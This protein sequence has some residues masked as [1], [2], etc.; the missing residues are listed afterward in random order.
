MASDRGIAARSILGESWQIVTLPSVAVVRRL[1]LDRVTRFGQ[2]RGMRVAV[3]GH[4]EW[5]EFVRVPRVPAAGEIV[6]TRDAWAEPGGGG[7]VA[8]V[9]LA[10][11]AG[12]CTFFTALA[13]DALRGDPC[14]RRDLA[15]PAG[16]RGADHCARIASTISTARSDGSW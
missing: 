4:V 6:H 12:E 5:I 1:R 10:R 11:L 2:H 13:D 7:A 16:R 14:V 9:E 3:I 15:A 8:A